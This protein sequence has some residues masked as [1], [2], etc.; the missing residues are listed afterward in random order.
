MF[1]AT[2]VP[3]DPRAQG[4]GPLSTIKLD[5]I[6]QWLEMNVISPPALI[7]TKK[8]NDR[9]LQKRRQ[10]EWTFRKHSRFAEELAEHSLFF[11]EYPVTED[12]DHFPS[13]EPLL[14]RQHGIWRSRGNDVFADFRV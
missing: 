11:T 12:S 14:Y 6:R 2:D 1:Q 9:D 4:L 5:A 13:I 3:F 10:Q 8:E 7:Q